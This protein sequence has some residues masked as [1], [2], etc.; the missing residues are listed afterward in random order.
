MVPLP[1]YDYNMYASPETKQRVLQQKLKPV[2][3]QLRAAQRTAAAA[4]QLQLEEEEAAYVSPTPTGLTTTRSRGEQQVQVQSQPPGPRALLPRA[5]REEEAD[6]EEA[7]EAARVVE[8]AAAETA[9]ET[10]AKRLGERAATRRLTKGK[11]ASGSVLQAAVT[12]SVRQRKQ[13]D[14][15]SSEAA[16]GKS[17]AD[18]WPS[19]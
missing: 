11:G 12:R 18:E 2:M 4:E 8:T 14:L 13:R 7:G 10:G 17:G 16:Q 9:A 15:D 3:A 6:G 19:E 5:S 1:Y